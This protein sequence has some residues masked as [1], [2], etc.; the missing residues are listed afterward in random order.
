[1][2]LTSLSLPS[3]YP[4][5]DDPRFFSFGPR[6]GAT[7][8][9]SGG[10]LRARVSR[11]RRRRRSFAPTTPTAPSRLCSKPVHVAARPADSFPPKR[12]RHADREVYSPGKF[13]VARSPAVLATY[14]RHR[15]WLARQNG[16]WRES[17]RLRE[18]KIHIFVEKY[19]D[20]PWVAWW[21][22]YDKRHPPTV[23]QSWWASRRNFSWRR[24]RSRFLLRH[25]NGPILKKF[26]TR[27]CNGLKLPN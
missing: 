8:S 4:L 20:S 23:V 17:H 16:V 2:T 18:K 15:Q 22:G 19:R 26:R 6:R 5:K 24:R 11:R 21:H 7:F 27:W 13:D 1:M 9:R 25:C 14:G 10:S 3:P 12:A